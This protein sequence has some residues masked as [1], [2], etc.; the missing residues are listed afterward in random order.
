MKT[1]A[2]LKKICPDCF[3]VKRKGTVYVRC[4]T[5]SKHKQRQGMMTAEGG[6]PEAHVCA[7]A[8]NPSMQQ[9]NGFQAMNQSFFTPQPQAQMS[10]P[11]FFFGMMTGFRG[12]GGPKF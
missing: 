11:Q 1:R 5:S 12:F 7:P 8:Q 4:T 10:K 3:F 9:K 6:A 2:S